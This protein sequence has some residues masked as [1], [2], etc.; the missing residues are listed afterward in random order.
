VSVIPFFVQLFNESKEIEYA[1]FSSLLSL[2]FASKITPFIPLLFNSS[3]N[4][5]VKSFESITKGLSS[6]K[7]NSW[8][9]VILIATQFLSC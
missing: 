3:I 1:K 7:V 6:I 9:F 2:S 4:S 8:A 5:S